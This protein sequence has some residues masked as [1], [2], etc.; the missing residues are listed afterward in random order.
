MQM[1][2]EVPANDWNMYDTIA[3]SSYFPVSRRNHGRQTSVRVSDGKVSSKGCQRRSWTRVRTWFHL[4]RTLEYSRHPNYF[5]VSVVGLSAPWLPG[6]DLP[7]LSAQG[8]SELEYFA[9]NLPHS[10][11]YCT[12]CFLILR[13]L[14]L[15]KSTRIIVYQQQR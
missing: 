12:R 15:L 1:A 7:L 8:I 6:S 2:A 5:C 3:A 10:A 13:R 4:E 14:C 11:L 9:R